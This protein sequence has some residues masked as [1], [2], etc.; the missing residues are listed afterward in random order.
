MRK[1]RTLHVVSPLRRRQRLGTALSVPGEVMSEHQEIN[2]V[3]PSSLKHIIGQQSVVAQV[4]VALEAA[5]ADDKKFDSALLVG[6][7]G[8]GKSALASVIAQEMATTFH[9]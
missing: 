4:E 6:P 7:P 1:E 3:A 5:F 2:D 8:V 9:E